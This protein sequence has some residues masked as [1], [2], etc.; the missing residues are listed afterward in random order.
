MLRGNHLATVDEKGRLK[1]PAAFLE[2]LRESWQPV[3]R[4]QRERRLRSDLPDEILE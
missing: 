4:D 1:I 2:S 3:F